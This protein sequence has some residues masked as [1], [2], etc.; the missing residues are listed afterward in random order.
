MQESRLRWYGHVL[1]LAERLHVKPGERK[2]KGSPRKAFGLARCHACQKLVENVAE[3]KVER[4][5]YE[6]D[7][8]F[9]R[10]K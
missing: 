9:N 8:E 4:V 7:P 5:K 2:E 3:D 1:R 6:A 10:Y